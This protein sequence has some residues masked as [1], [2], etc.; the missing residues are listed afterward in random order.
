MFKNVSPGFKQFKRTQRSNN[1]CGAEA[2]HTADEN[3][4]I[5]LYKHIKG[6]RGHN[7]SYLGWILS[8]ILQLSLKKQLSKFGLKEHPNLSK[9]LHKTACL[10]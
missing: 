6:C 1:L 9:N 8:L 2:E 4:F 3:F 5:T 10:A 7:Y